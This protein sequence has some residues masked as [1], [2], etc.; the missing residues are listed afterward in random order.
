MNALLATASKGIT[1][2]REGLYAIDDYAYY[3]QLPPGVSAVI[4]E[5][6]GKQSLLSGIT[7]KV[8]S[9]EMVF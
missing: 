7:S 3:I 2:I 9:Y 1:K 6:E 4:E 5:K 8:F